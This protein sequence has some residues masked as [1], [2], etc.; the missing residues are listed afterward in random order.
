MDNFI[1]RLPTKIVFGKGEFSKLGEEAKGLGRKALIVTG[2]KFAKESGL[3]E[4]AEELL[5]KN[6]V[7]YVIFS[8]I[9]PNPESETVDKGGR[10][11]RENGVDFIV[12]I[13]GGSVIDAAK[14]IA[15]VAVSSKPIWDYCERPPKEKVPQ[16][17]LPI[18]A[19]ITVAATG[20]EA[21]AG[22]VITNTKTRE[23]RGFFGSSN[24]PRV[25]IVDPML[26]VSMPQKQTIDGVVDMFVH[27]LESYLSSK[28][29]APVSDRVA[30]GL[31]REAIREGQIVFNDL[32]N[33]EARESLSWISTLALSGFPSAGRSGPF[34]IHRLEH[35]I[36]GIYPTKVSHGRGLAILLP[37]FLYHTKEMHEERLKIFGKEIFSTDSPSKTIERIVHWMKSI[38][39]FN[40]LKEYGVKMEDLKRFVQMALAD[41]GNND[42][43]SARE[44]INIETVLKIYETAFDYKDLFRKA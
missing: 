25:S 14:G 12:G 20:S 40:S 10:I 35:P 3:L 9:E 16:N 4:K 38:D 36:S 32:K 19:V 22:A 28:A 24:F 30:E 15:T 29:N 21:D 17:T 37:S 27:I 43:L 13:G 31:M 18:L 23:K 8:E 44:P 11:A 26:T 5:Q 33:I 42:M 6:E 41:D 39:A 34:P 7:D 1:F 2:R